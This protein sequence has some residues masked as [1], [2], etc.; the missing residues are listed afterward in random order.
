M[1]PK[2]RRFLALGAGLALARPA[3]AALPERR[4]A[5]VNLHTGEALDVV[6]WAQGRYLDDALAALAHLMRDHRSGETGPMAPALFDVLHDL[7]RSLDAS[8]P[9]EVV[10]AYRSPASNEWL[11]QNTS[12][13]ARASLHT[14]GMAADVRLPERPLEDLHRAALGLQAGGVGLYPGSGFVH[15][16]VGR[17]RSWVG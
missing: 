9:L 3:L 13:V 15:V 10:S 4:L 12:G 8:G 6:Y 7:A 16:D 5:L 11:V 1:N 14:R 2:R 17:V